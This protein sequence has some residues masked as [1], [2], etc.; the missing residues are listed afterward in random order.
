[1][2]CQLSAFHPKLKNKAVDVEFLS[3]QMKFPAKS[4]H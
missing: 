4:Q 2:T 3:K 1:M